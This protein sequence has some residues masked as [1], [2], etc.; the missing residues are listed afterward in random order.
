MSGLQK[1]AMPIPIDPLTTRAAS[2]LPS[3]AQTA[4]NPAGT[5]LRKAVGEQRAK[6]IIEPLNLGAN[7]PHAEE[8]KKTL[9]NIK[10]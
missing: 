2:K 5:A 8:Q 10:D 1:I 4:V 7:N 6:T 9:L 3:G